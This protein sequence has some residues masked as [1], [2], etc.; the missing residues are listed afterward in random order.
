MSTE[1]LGDKVKGMYEDRTRVYLPR[2]AYTVIRID[3]KN[4]SSY[5]RKLDKP[6][7]LALVEDFD[8]TAIGLCSDIMGCRLAYTQSDEI[9]LVLTDF[10]APNTD[11][12]FDGNM[13]KIASVAASMATMYFNR[14]RDSR[15][16]SPDFNSK[17]ALFDAR[18]FSVSDFDGVR[19]C[20][21]WRQADAVRNSVQMI[22]RS[23]MSD[24]ELHGVGVHDMRRLISERGIDMSGFSQRVLRGGIVMKESYT[25]AV[26]EEFSGG[27][28]SAIVQRSRWVATPAPNFSD[29][30]WLDEVLPMT[31]RPPRA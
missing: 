5:T 16:P 28:E 20:L 10:D 23:V 31:S 11:A 13:Q 4:F 27:K 24:K 14:A 18:C 6:F 1:S 15:S 9:T 17:G 3:G 26:P 25:A 8:K 29:S 12:W 21:T 30:R 2:R 22:A 7:D 19:E